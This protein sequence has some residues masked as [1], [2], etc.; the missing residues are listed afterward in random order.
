MCGRYG[1]EAE[2]EELRLQFD[3]YNR[4]TGYEAREEIY[5]SEK[6]AIIIQEDDKNYMKSAA[7]GFCS[8]Y[9]SR[10]LINA[11]GESVHEKKTFKSL[12]FN[13]RC[14]VPATCFFEWK[15]E[16]KS[17]TKYI[18]KVEDPP[19]FGMA[20]LYQSDIDKNGQVI[21]RYIVITSAANPVMAQIHERMPVILSKEQMKLWL[22]PHIADIEVLKHMLKP[23]DGGIKPV[24]AF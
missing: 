2:Y 8:P 4:Y 12:L 1:L 7:W 24:S 22:D 18:I 11:R 21:L 23:Y 19:I 3:I 16:D 14:I 6:A 17:K 15:K 10:L 9:D 5:P 20:G 13:S